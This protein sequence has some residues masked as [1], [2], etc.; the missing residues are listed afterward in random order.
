M[1]NLSRWPGLSRTGIGAAMVALTAVAGYGLGFAHSPNA[2]VSAAPSAVVS[3]PVDPAPVATSYAKVVDAVAPAV[4]T[5]RVEKRATVRQAQF[6]D[7]DLFRF[8]GREFQGPRQ[9]RTPRQSGLGSGVLTTADGYILTNNHVIDG[10]DTVRIELTDKRVFDAKV[11]GK[12]PASD[13]AVLKI[14]ATG[15]PTIAIGDSNRVRVGDV[16]LAVGN[17]L[18]VGQTVTAGIISAKGRATGV[19]DGGYEDF[20]QTDAPI[21]QGNSGG[22]LVN[23]SGELVGINSQILSQSGG[24]IGLGFA[25][26]SNMAREVMTQLKAEGKV[27]RGKLGVMIQGVTGDLAASLKLADTSG[28]LV[29]GVEPGGAA[30]R[31]GVEQGDVITSINGEKVVDSNTLRNR[32]AATKPGSTVDLQVFRNGKTETLHA[33]LGALEPADEKS[34]RD[35]EHE[36]G[37]GPTGMAVETLTPQVARQLGL[38]GRQEGVVIRDVDPD[39]AAAASGLQPGDVIRQVNRQAVK[40]PTEL[41]SAIAASGE[42]PALLLVTRKGADIFVALQN[43]QP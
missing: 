17:P 22:A 5:V 12:D 37:A 23:L 13:L 28:A 6:P 36:G 42:R 18:G 2:G 26:P 43:R 25:I 34:A 33:T 40:T 11:V 7:D 10:A 9:Q 8:F 29:S 35:D 16:V 31:A 21:N 32:I 4:V 27:Q 3:G 14:A 38:T 30:A 20:L 19:G 24:N 39:G 41:K 1:R 15:L